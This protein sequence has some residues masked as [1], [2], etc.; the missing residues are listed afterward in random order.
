MP[1]LFKELRSI[2]EVEPPSTIVRIPP[3][4]KLEEE[5]TSLVALLSASSTK[6]DRSTVIEEPFSIS[7][8]KLVPPKVAPVRFWSSVLEKELKS[9]VCVLPPSVISK[10]V[11]FKITPV[12]NSLAGSLS[13]SSTPSCKAAR[14]TVIEAPPS[15]SIC[16]E[17][18]VKVAPVRF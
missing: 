13:A 16:R 8:C 4:F 9:T 5:M 6:E 11:P 10:S 1:E 14:T 17:V 12:L 18:P 15:I 2:E 3:A 7:I